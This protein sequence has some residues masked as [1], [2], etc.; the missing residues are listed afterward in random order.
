M[1]KYLPAKWALSSLIDGLRPVLLVL[2]LTAASTIA[3]YTQGRAAALRESLQAKVL[4]CNTCHGLHAEGYRGWFPIP[5][6]AGQQ[7]QYTEN[8]LRAFIERQRTNPVMANVS[9]AL[10]PSMVSALARYFEGLSPKPIGGAPRRSLALGKE[11]FNNG[12]PE[13]NVPACTPCHG[14]DAKGHNE[15]PRLAG[16]LYEYTVSQLTNWSRLRGQGTVVDTSAVMAPSAHNLT[17]A[18]IDAIAAYVSTLQ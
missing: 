11:I 13:S 4:Y 9:H 14:A 10:T 17:K 6:L 8:Q 1:A 7:S 2:L 3:T 5:R 12:L 15:N 16:Q 18:Q